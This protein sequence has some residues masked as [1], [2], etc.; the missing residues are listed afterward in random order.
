[1]MIPVMM[2][3]TRRKAV[4]PGHFPKD[5]SHIQA[6]L[7]TIKRRKQRHCSGLK[8]IAACYIMLATLRTVG[9]DRMFVVP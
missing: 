7:L 2:R 3:E 9:N 4:F 1:M 6:L 5:R 8:L